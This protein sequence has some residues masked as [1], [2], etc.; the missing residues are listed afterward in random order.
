[1]DTATVDKWIEGVA[2]ERVRTAIP[3][4]FP[5]LP[6]IPARRYTDSDFFVQE[7][8]ALWRGS[9]L[10]AGHIDQLR[11]PG[12]FFVWR[13]GSA[14]ILV[15]R[16]DDD[17]IRAFYN[18][19]R[20]RG[21]PIARE[22]EG[23]LSR[24][25]VCGYHGWTYDRQGNLRG[26]TDR[27]DW[28]QDVKSNRNLVP[29]RCELFGNWIFL[30][31][32][33]DEP[34]L[35]EFL[36]PIARNFAHL[37]LETLRLVSR[38]RHELACNAKI[39]I[40]N[41]LEAYHFRMLHAGTTDRIFDNS[42]TRIFLWENGHSMMLSP[43]R[44]DGWVDPGTVGMPEIPNATEIER[45]HNPSYSIFPNFI[46]P[47]SPTG[48]PA[49]SI[50]PVTA[51][52]SVLE[53]LWFAPG[54]GDGPRPPLWDQRIANFD[55][56]VDEDIQFADSMQETVDSPGCTGVPL[57]YQERRI[58]HWHE[59]LDRRI[60]RERVSPTLRVEPRLAPFLD[61]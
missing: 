2:E 46:L 50:W 56:I 60:G 10:Y 3:E 32:S 52:T 25:V 7:R 20:H 54:W 41:F 39:V 11:E 43:N 16:G 1:M 13:Y 55:R 57:S 21:A 26:V 19:C 15:V 40:E 27:R 18:T 28:P 29:V 59:E 36:K 12:S 42:G 6:D 58:Y 30:C 24:A 33:A 4:G 61:D 17:V 51:Q 8:Q 9:W 22:E 31:E 5:D 23:Q 44:R 47:V 48:M 49:V 14:P 53:V 45:R 34:P 35:A 38:R 37:Q